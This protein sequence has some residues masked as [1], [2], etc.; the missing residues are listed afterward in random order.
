VVLAI[1]GTL[2]LEDLINDAHAE[3]VHMLSQSNQPL[4]RL[5]D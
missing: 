3:P 4:D 5:V 2:S 1:R